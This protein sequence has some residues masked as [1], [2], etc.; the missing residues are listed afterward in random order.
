MKK[1][2]PVSNYLINFIY[3]H[4]S[5]K[6]ECFEKTRFSNESKKLL[7]ILLNKITEGDLLFNKAQINKQPIKTMPISE[8][9]H[10]LDTKIKT[11]IQNMKYIGYL[12]EFTIQSRKIKVYFIHEVENIESLFFQNAIKIVYIWLFIAQHFSKSE[13]SQTL[14]IYFYLTNIK[15]QISEE[16]NVLDRE[17]IN[18]G[19]TF[20]CKQDNEINI[21]R[22]EE[23]FKVFIH[24][25]FHSFGL[26]FSHR[27]CSH[28]DKKIL[29]LFPVNIDLRIYETYCEIWAELINIMFIIHSSS[30]SGENKTDGLNNIIKKLEKAIDYERMFSLFQCSKILTHYGISY[31]HLHER[32]QEAIIARKLRYKENTPILSYYIIKSFLIYK[33]NHFIEWCVVHNGLS[34]R[35]GENDIDLNKNLND[36]Y[37]LIREHY[38]NKKYTECLENLC[39]WFKKQKKTKR[40]D[41]IELKTMRMTLFENI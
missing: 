4:I 40:K 29:N 41:D 18:T 10:L 24:E 27:E 17:H 2:T 22:K 33:V 32:T 8:Y 3:T 16:N 14:N 26:D 9:F 13:C 37:E 7:L 39:E 31:K 12:Y 36:Y 5:H 23:W 28:I 30:S 1:N 25:C 19:F 21:F 15:K 35:F 38:S 34:I 11:H 20:A 6:L